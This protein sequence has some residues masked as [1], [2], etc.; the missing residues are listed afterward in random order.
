MRPEYM[1][2]DE[3]K[4]EIAEIDRQIFDLLMKRSLIYSMARIRYVTET[5]EEADIVRRLAWDRYARYGQP[6]LRNHAVVRIVTEEREEKERIPVEDSDE[7]DDRGT[8]EDC[9]REP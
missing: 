5:E 9:G 6:V 1:L 7:C 2:T 8:E 4:R 3:Q